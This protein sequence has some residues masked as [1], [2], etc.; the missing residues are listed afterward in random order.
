MPSNVHTAGPRYEG[1]AGFVTTP[2]Y[3]DDSPQRLL[4]LGAGHIGVMQRVLHVPDYGY[5]LDE[6]ARS[7]DLMVEAATALA[8]SHCQV[9]GQ[10]GTNWVHCQGTTGPDDI[11]AFCAETSAAI[12]VP[13]LMAGHCIVLALRELGA[14]R[15]TVSNGYYRDDWRDGINGYLAAAGFEIV[16]SGHMRD[17]GIYAALDEQMQVEADTVWDHPDRDCVQTILRAHD[18]GPEADVIVQTGSGMR[19]G[20]H[21]ASLEA[22]CGKPVVASDNAL[23]WAMLRALDLGRPVRGWGHLLA[24]V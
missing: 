9:V 17:Q 23:Q 16:A 1:Y 20:P 18:A 12:G 14:R 22:A 13:F 11:E 19:I 5:G 2:R 21:V 4:E 10:A 8:E 6:R 3:F 7:F 15:I 24:S